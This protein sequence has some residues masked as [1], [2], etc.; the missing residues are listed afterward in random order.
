MSVPTSPSLALFAALLVFISQAAFASLPNCNSVAAGQACSFTNVSD[1]EGGVFEHVSFDPLDEGDTLSIVEKFE[2]IAAFDIAGGSGAIRHTSEH[3]T[4]FPGEGTEGGAVSGEYRIDMGYFAATRVTVSFNTPVDAVGG[5]FGGAPGNASITVVLEDGSSV[6]VT[7]SDAGIP[8]VPDITASPESECTAI[9]GFLGIDSGGGAK[10]VQVVFLVSRDAASLDSLFLG[11]AE[12]GSHG[13]GVVR[14]PESGIN[15]NCTA[16]GYPASPVLPQSATVVADIDGD[17]MPN[18]WEQQYGLNPLD[19]SD[20]AID[21]DGDG[22]ANLTEFIN[23]TDPTYYDATT[24]N[25][26]DGNVEVQGV[27]RLTPQSVPPVNCMADTEGAMYYDSALGMTLMCDGVGWQ[28]YRGPQGEVGPAGPQG[29]PGEPGVK[30]DKGDKG[31]IGPQGPQGPVGPQGPKGDKGEPGK[32]A[33]FANISCSTNQIIRYNGTAWECATDILQAL[34]LS[35]K[36]GDTI[37]LKNGS[38]Q[39][40][41]LPGQG[42]GRG[43]W[44]HKPKDVKDSKKD[45]HKHH[46][47]HDD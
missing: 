26:L 20:A 42:I 18:D 5:F 19:A 1:F 6:D 33:P 32:D 21:S 37:I 13:P 12:G 9:N 47:Q 36:D 43:Q 25:K 27:L 24:P 3:A 22:I 44:K 2:N 4:N 30:G 14:F 10:I 40:A 45:K 28:A 17:G 11:T 23:G 39:C 16:L 35:C 29:M 41:H 15:S 38:W 46:K 34:T 8:G 7:L 31:D